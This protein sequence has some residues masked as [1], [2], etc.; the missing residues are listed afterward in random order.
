MLPTISLLRQYDEFDAKDLR[1]A[2]TWNKLAD[3]INDEYDTLVEYRAIPRIELVRHSEP[4]ADL[5]AMQMDFRRKRLKVS[6]LNCQHPV[7]SRRTN[8]RFRI[9]HDIVHCVLNADFDEDGEYKVFQHQSE[10]LPADLVSALYTEIVIQASHKIHYGYFA[11]Q[12][13]FLAGDI[14]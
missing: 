10:G 8:L 5:L 3:Q 12:K 9:L 7:F 4:Y 2:S 6:V 14:E 11:E 1:H 13:L